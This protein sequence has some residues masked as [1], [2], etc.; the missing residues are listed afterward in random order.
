MGANGYLLSRNSSMP[1]RANQLSHHSNALDQYLR[2]MAANTTLEDAMGLEWKDFVKRPKPVVW[3]SS[4]CKTDSRREDYVKELSRFI[5]VDKFGK[6]G[7]FKCGKPYQAFEEKCWKTI[8]KKRYLFALAFE[9][10]LC[11]HYL[12]EKPY[13][14]LKYGLVPIV[15]GGDG[16]EE[17][18]PPGSFINARL[19]H[20][21]E[22]AK[23]LNKL[24]RDPVAYGRYHVWRKYWEAFVR[25]NFCE[26][27]HRLHTDPVRGHHVDIPAWRQKA[28]QCVIPPK[29]LFRSSAWKKII[30]NRK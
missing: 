11:N 23:L 12:S 29:N 14:P 21:R 3:M 19:Y 1:L 10:S 27:C 24:Q 18:L 26:L 5:N 7:W 30:H 17:F 13:N 2:A 22:L 6:C 15:W 4:N 20:P 28:E 16:Y 25:G 8:L 9:N